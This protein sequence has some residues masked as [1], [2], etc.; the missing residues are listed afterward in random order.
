VPVRTEE[1]LN[2]GV[3]NSIRMPSALNSG[4]ATDAQVERFTVAG[5]KLFE[6]PHI[7]MECNLE[8]RM[9][10]TTRKAITCERHPGLNRELDFN[11][12]AGSPCETTAWSVQV[13]FEGRKRRCHHAAAIKTRRRG[14]PRTLSGFCLNWS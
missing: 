1:W 12:D 7:K 11:A 10:I 13:R 5:W 9:W 14:S 2:F 4:L 6:R 3:V 8:K